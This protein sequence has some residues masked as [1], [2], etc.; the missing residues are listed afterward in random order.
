MSPQTDFTDY[1]IR[2]VLI[3]CLALILAITYDLHAQ[4]QPE[5]IDPCLTAIE[6]SDMAGYCLTSE[7]F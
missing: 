6:G 5:L 7:E 1:A 4:I 2:T 3:V